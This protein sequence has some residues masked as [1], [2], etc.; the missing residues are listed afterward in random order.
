MPPFEDN[1]TRPSRWELIKQR[2]LQL[3]LRAQIIVVII[4]IV[5]ITGAVVAAS[6]IIANP[7]GGTP[8]VGLKFNPTS[9]AIGSILTGDVLTLDVVLDTDGQDVAA[10]AAVINF[11]STKFTIDCIDTTNCKGVTVNSTVF[12]SIPEIRRSGDQLR[13]VAGNVAGIS[14]N[15]IQVATVTFVVLPNANFG[16]TTLAFNQIDSA[17][18]ANDGFGT[19]IA[20][21][22]ANEEFNILLLNFIIID[23]PTA[24]VAPGGT[25]VQIDWT[26]SLASDGAVAVSTTSC[27][28]CSW[29]DFIAAGAN[30]TNG[31]GTDILAHSVT[32]NG[33]TADTGYFYRV[34]STRGISQVVSE[35]MSFYTGNVAPPPRTLII[36]NLSADTYAR[37][38]VIT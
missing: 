9:D 10:V 13:I 16:P 19:D 14:G 28:G 12:D 8:G 26:T 33:L 22:Y 24:T 29:S 34:R 20:G 15:D 11:D 25:S 27:P 4:G 5:I 17:I 30:V 36:S 21:F 18:V 35:E 1:S 6:T 7:S 31:S 3:S 37:S 32:V 2:F 38:A 23:G